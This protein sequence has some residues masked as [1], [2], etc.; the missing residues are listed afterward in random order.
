MPET[1]LRRVKP[2][3][4]PLKQSPGDIVHF[5]LKGLLPQGHMLALNMVLGTLSHISHNSDGAL[6]LAEQ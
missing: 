6:L 1:T 2:P 3:T 4:R 5:P